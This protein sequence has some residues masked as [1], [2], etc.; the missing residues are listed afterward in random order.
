MKYVNY[1]LIFDRN[2]CTL[3]F[4]SYFCYPKG[5][6]NGRYKQTNRFLLEKL[7]GSRNNSQIVHGYCSSV[8]WDNSGSCEDSRDKHKRIANINRINL[9]LNIK[10]DI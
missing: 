9:F 10:N 2:L 7:Q 1:C 3:K 5:F 4:I 8:T 6:D